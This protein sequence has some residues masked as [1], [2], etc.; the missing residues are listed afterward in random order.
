[1]ARAFVAD[2]VTT[3][4]C[5]PH[6]LPGLYHNTGPAILDAVAQ[7]QFALTLAGV[8]LQLVAGADVHLM[9]NLAAGLRSGQVLSL[10]SSRYVLVEP[11]H[12]VMP[13]RIEDAFFDLVSAGY[14]PILTHP[15]RLTWI[16][17]NYA[18]V[19]KLARCGA[20]MQLTAGSLTGD[21]GKSARYWG[22]RLI[23]DGLAHIVATDSHDCVRRPPILGRAR[24]YLVK[25]VGEQE[26]DNLVRVRPTGILQNVATSE[27]LLPKSVAV[28]SRSRVADRNGDRAGL[29]GRLRRIFG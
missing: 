5:T 9:P 10:N 17:D 7:L 8:P 21:F 4:A 22:E 27:L 18:T 28:G 24:D 23:D 16:A 29:S 6:I 15:E 20:L 26:A 25:R 13:L 12:H 3:V 11:P 19:V 2:G 1:M 14:V